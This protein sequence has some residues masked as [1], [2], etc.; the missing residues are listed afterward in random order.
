MKG[1]LFALF[2]SIVLVGCSTTPNKLREDA[3]TGTYTSKK[4]PKEIM[5][6]IADSWENYAVVNTREMRTGYA[7]SAFLSDG[8]LRYLADVETEHDIT[9]TRLY[10]WRVLAIGADPM[11]VF[12]ENCH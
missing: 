2:T 3:P 5:L 7:V 12:V 1:I 10:R 8:K 9:I 6:C 11:V 4:E